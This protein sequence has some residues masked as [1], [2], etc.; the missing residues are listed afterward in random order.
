MV[1]FDRKL[2]PQAIE[3]CQKLIQ[4]EKFTI[5]ALD[6]KNMKALIK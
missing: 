2:R 3:I 1:S 5:D 4:A 6:T